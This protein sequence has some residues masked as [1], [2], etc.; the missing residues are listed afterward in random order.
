MAP[1]IDRA[2]CTRRPL[3]VQRCGRACA[4]WGVRTESGAG[5]CVSARRP[6]LSGRSLPLRGLRLTAC[7]RSRRSL[8]RARHTTLVPLVGARDGWNGNT[9]ACLM[10]ALQ[11]TAGLPTSSS[12]VRRCGRPPRCDT[13]GPCVRSG[14]APQEPWRDP[15]LITSECAHAEACGTAGHLRVALPSGGGLAFATVLRASE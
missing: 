12:H 11:A 8:A 14:P 7:V 9:L 4:S 15:R 3:C 1:R 6:P 5:V 2:M 10:S 13:E